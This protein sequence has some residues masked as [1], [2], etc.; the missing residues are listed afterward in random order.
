MLHQLTIPLLQK[1][2]GCFYC[3]ETKIS[4]GICPSWTFP[5]QS[6][7]ENE[8]SVVI[9][10]NLFGGKILET[11]IMKDVHLLTAERDKVPCLHEKDLTKR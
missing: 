5:F 11:L 8:L 1:P 7:S 10:E 2:N 4:Q 6:T 3:V 9:V